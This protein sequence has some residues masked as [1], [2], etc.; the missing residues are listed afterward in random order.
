MKK[1]NIFII[2][3]IAIL[4]SAVVANVA[5]AK[6]KINVTVQT[7]LASQSSQHIDPRL[8][9]LIKELKSV[10]RYSSYR[11]LNE[12]QLRLTK[13]VTGTVILPGNRKMKITAMGINGNRINLNLEIL[14]NNQ[15]I[16]QTKI[17][18]LNNS[19]LIVGGPK[20]QKGYLLFNIFGSF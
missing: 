13:F 18:L 12:N 1:F 10:F 4:L 9:S 7:V 20:Y 5:L 19:N 11:L 17:K 14:K 15:S 3:V 6:E 2:S 8:S 16:F